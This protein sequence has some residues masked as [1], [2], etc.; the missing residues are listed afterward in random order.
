MRTSNPT[1]TLIATAA[2]KALQQHHAE[3]RN[4]QVRDLFSQDPARF[5]TLS[6]EGAGLFLDY[7]KNSVD[8]KTMQLLCDLAR[9]TQVETQREAMFS[10][11]IN[12]TEHRAVLHT[13]LR[14]PRSDQLL[15]DGLD[16]IRIFM[17]CWIVWAY[18]PNAYVQ[19]NDAATM[20]AKKL[21]T[22]ST[23]A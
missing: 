5:T 11:K 8:E 7:S 14:R 13:A 6:I 23:S 9:E 16:I 15:L 1:S 22:S 10:G 18:F 4:R 20:V 17:Q 2:F 12:R 3:T 19:A 21:P